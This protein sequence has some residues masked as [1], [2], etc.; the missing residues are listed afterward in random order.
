M[1]RYASRLTFGSEGTDYEERITY[2]RMREQRLAKARAALK[3]HKIA[4]ALLCQADNVR[5]VSGIA[6]P[7]F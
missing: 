2:A 5:Y 6:F 1:A 7:A 4:A 3:K